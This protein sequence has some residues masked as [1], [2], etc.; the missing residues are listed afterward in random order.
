MKKLSKH[1]RPKKAIQ[2]KKWEITQHFFEV[3][4]KNEEN[5]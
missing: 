3:K 1:T 5:N 4:Q 2:G